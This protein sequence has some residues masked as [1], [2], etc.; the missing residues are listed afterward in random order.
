MIGNIAV[1]SFIIFMAAFLPLSVFL[2]FAHN[3]REKSTHKRL[4]GY[5]MSNNNES[6]TLLSKKVDNAIQQE[7]VSI[8]IKLLVDVRIWISLSVPCLFL[9]E[10]PGLKIVYH[11]CLETFPIYIV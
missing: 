7:L 5:N 9:I 10:K 6:I 1:R 3:I 4:M 8:R 11:I 2:F